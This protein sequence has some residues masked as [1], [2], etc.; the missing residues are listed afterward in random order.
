MHVS[1][2]L[3]RDEYLA[4][5]VKLPALYAT[6]DGQGANEQYEQVLS[7]YF[8]SKEDQLWK[9]VA[10]RQGMSI[11]AVRMD[12]ECPHYVEELLR[13]RMYAAVPRV[14]T[15]FNDLLGQ[16]VAWV[17]VVTYVRDHVHAVDLEVTFHSEVH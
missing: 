17:Q 11:S 10:Q 7:A 16:K 6:L 13:E 5:R 2:P 12:P 14:A 1:I 15:L 4:A 8:P 9:E 3:S